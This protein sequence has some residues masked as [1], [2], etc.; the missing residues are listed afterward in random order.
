MWIS[1]YLCIATPHI[2]KYCSCRVMSNYEV[3]TFIENPA[4][5]NRNSVFRKLHLPILGY[6]QC[7]HT[8]LGPTVGHVMLGDCF[9]RISREYDRYELIFGEI[10]TFYR[11][12]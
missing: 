12:S 10:V 1:E 4:I 11:L 2:E 5:N 3:I 9:V 8:S 6:G 7:V